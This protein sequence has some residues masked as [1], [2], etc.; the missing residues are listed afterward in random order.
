[1]VPEIF[2]KIHFDPDYLDN[3]SSIHFKI[4]RS[5]IYG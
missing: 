5:P 2:H 3:G 1:M 4:Y